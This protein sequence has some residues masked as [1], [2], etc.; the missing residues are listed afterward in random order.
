MDTRLHGR[1]ALVSGGAGGLGTAFARA[2]HA[3]RPG[4]VVVDD[5]TVPS[6]RVPRL[7][8]GQP[9]TERRPGVFARALWRVVGRGPATASTAA[10]GDLVAQLERLA[11]LHRAG[12]LDA[13]EF[14]RA[15]ARLLG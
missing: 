10:G 2:L 15:K 1:V 7:R 11:A 6:P 9:G 5:R 3:A 13:A 14:A 4:S 8:P 12:D